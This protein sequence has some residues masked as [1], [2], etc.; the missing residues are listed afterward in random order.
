MRYKSV[1]LFLF[2]LSAGFASQVTNNEISP[3]NTIDISTGNYYQNLIIE[4]DNV[5]YA[6]DNNNAVLSGNVVLLH[7]GLIVTSNKT[8]INMK[9][10]KLEIPEQFTYMNHEQTI[11]GDSL[12]YDFANER[13]TGEDIRMRLY[14]NFIKGDSVIIEKDRVIVT[15]AYQS[16]CSK[17]PPCHHITTRK[18]T[19]YPEWSNIV[20]EDAYFHIMNVPV[21]WTPSYIME[22]GRQDMLEHMSNA[23]P[24][25]GY[26]RVEGDY[27]KWGSSY[28]KNEKMYGTLDVEYTTFL[29]FRIG[30]TNLYKVD[31]S[32]MGNVRAHYRVGK[33][34]MEFGWQHRILLGVPHKE[35]AQIIDD[36]FSGVLPP[37]NEEYPE[38]VIDVTEKELINYQW[39]SYKPNVTFISPEYSIFTPS[40][41]NRLTSSFGYIEEEVEPT[42]NTPD[43]IKTNEFSK[44]F[45]QYQIF[46]SFH[47]PSDIEIKPGITYMTTAY[48]KGFSMNDAWKRFYYT[49]DFMDEFHP[50]DY[51]LSYK[52]TFEEYGSSPFEFDKFNISTAEEISFFVNYEMFKDWELSYHIDYSLTEDDLRN[53]DYGIKTVWCHWKVGVY[54]YVNLERFQLEISL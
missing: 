53:Q 34:R 40:I 12:S 52:N 19:I 51:R 49:F 54:W 32:Q 22:S 8:F 41:K 1:C 50:F 36:F 13:G 21:M 10:E 2:L 5:I 20:A 26:N 48:Y 39:V 11:V 45:L 37:S 16:I 18:M 44:A 27:L 4:S 33:D 28:Y 29:S 42:E 17:D 6:E 23:I 31:Q 24:H 14:G 9:T 30:V 43:E 15:N 35:R 3:H 7:H 46:R 38:L 47:F 25:I